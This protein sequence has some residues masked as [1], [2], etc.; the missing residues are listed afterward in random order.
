MS[1]AA[2]RPAEASV[3]AFPPSEYLRDE[4]DARSWTADDFA[5]RAGWTTAKAQ[6]ILDSRAEIGA[7]AAE[8]IAGVLG[9]SP[10]VWINLARRWDLQRTAASSTSDSAPDPADGQRQRAQPAGSAPSVGRPA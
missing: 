8:A 9:T 10:G 5:E 4:L 2:H 1:A 7:E 3:P 6:E